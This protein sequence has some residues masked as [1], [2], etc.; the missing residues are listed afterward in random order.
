MLI[1]INDLINE[2]IRIEN[3]IYIHQSINRNDVIYKYIRKNH[4][5]EM[6]RN[7]QLY[8]SNRQRFSDRREKKWKENNRMR[9]LLCPALPTEKEKKDYGLLSNKIEEAYNICI[10]CWTYDRHNACD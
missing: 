5:I 6:I 9:F 1:T 10:S 7:M 4:F 2:H 3:G 8:I